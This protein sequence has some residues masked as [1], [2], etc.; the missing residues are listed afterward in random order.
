MYNVSMEPMDDRKPLTPDTFINRHLPTITKVFPN[1]V[2]EGEGEAAADLIASLENQVWKTMS[3]D[4]MFK[5]LGR[6]GY[7]VL[8]QEERLKILGDAL[9]LL[10][11]SQDAD[12]FL[13]E[14]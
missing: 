6:N 11:A 13:K 5:R 8:P 7:D 9:R 3:N 12:R 1:L 14:K 2:S 10:D 4:P